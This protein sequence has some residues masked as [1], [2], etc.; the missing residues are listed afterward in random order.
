MTTDGAPTWMAGFCRVTWYSMALSTPS[1]SLTGY[2]LATR[3]ARS[4]SLEG[5]TSSR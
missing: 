5:I 1:A 4:P 3:I 2:Q